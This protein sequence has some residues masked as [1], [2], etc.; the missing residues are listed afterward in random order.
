MTF[1]EVGAKLGT[2]QPFIQYPL[3]TEESE[4]RVDTVRNK[5]VISPAWDYFEA[6]WSTTYEVYDINDGN[7]ERY[8]QPTPRQRCI[9]FMKDLSLG[10][11]PPT[12]QAMENDHIKYKQMTQGDDI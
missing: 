5:D 7:D 8:Q 1:E 4:W 10:R 3:D 9:A 12:W 6:A 11:Q 2:L